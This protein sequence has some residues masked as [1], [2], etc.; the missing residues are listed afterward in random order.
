M[1]QVK[2][3]GD[4]FQ[5]EVMESDVPVLVDFWAEWCGPCRMVNPILDELSEQYSGKLKIAKVNV[6]D[7][8]EIAQKYG[9]MSIP[10][11]IVF[12]GG[13]KIDQFVGA[14]PK[15]A[16]VKHIEEMLGKIK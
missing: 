3:S 8:Q 9:V 13:E 4:N 12:N 15:D 7:N 11:F 10:T 16:F 6:D 2:I 14:L 1:T 5:P